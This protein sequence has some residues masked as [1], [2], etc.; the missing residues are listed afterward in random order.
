MH[1]LESY[2]KGKVRKTNFQTSQF[3]VLKNLIDV[4]IFVP[5]VLTF[6]ILSAFSL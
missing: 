4:K 6:V 1:T 5:I 2:Q 3:F